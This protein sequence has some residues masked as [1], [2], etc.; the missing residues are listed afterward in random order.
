[1]SKE[2][3]SKDG[4]PSAKLVDIVIEVE[5]DTSFKHLIDFNNQLKKSSIKYIKPESSFVGIKEIRF[6]SNYKEV[7]IN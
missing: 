3:P 7:I 4:T 5:Q 1:V 2:H 6:E